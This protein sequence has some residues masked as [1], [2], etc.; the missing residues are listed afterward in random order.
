V[1]AVNKMDLVDWDEDVYSQIVDDFSNFAAKLDVVDIT[2]IP[3][4]ALYG[5]NVV[6]R[7]DNM[8]WYQ[9]TPLLYHLD[10]IHIASDRNLIDPRLPVQWVVRAD[11]D[12]QRERGYAGKLAGGIWRAGD[13]V[14]VLPSGGRSVVKSVDTHDGA[15][16]EA[17]PPMTVSIRLTDDLDV[18]RGDML[19]RPHNR[20]EMSREID[21]ML[22][23][24]G[25]TPATE[26]TRLRA[27]ARR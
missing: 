22:C 19:C 12:Q 10:H 24:M 20:P 3:I 23:W 13:E 1:V 15:L 14:L 5:D 11:A 18:S 8:P 27:R 21:A 16:E 7:S 26:G 9:G 6:E 2:S 17:F 4:S 25:H